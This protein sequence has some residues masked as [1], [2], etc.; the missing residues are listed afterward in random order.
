M[1]V[2]ELYR[3]FLKALPQTHSS[4]EASNIT[5]SIF[6]YFAGIDRSALIKDPNRVLDE[7][8]IGLIN[9]SLAALKKNKPVQYITGEA[10][11]YKMKLKVSPAVLIPRPETEELAEAVIHHIK[12]KQ[13]IK[14]ID[15]GTGS[16]CIAIAIKK[17]AT[18]STITAIDISDDA[19]L[20]AKENASTQN[21]SIHFLQTDFLSEKNW[22]LLEK[23]DVIV[24]NPPYI[25]EKEMGKMDKNVTAY[26]P[27]TAL[28][29]ENN[30][31]LIFYEKIA[32]FGKQ[33][34]TDNGM[35]FL[36]T[37]EDLAEE[38]CKLF[39]DAF[40]KAIIKNDLFGKQRMVIATKV[41]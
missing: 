37:H 10:W 16:G 22:G 36:E 3:S 12:N 34:L 33:H 1:T 30:R 5:S 29:V 15:I 13:A 20:I 9:E 24:S 31:P 4:H 32:A 7:K 40:Y 38:T 19:L 28:F 27:H 41:F 14:I 26:E 11:F 21:T 23:Y 6:E 35:I 18:A 8:T 17:N 2:N 25:P 39:N